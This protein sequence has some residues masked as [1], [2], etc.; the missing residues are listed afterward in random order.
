MSSMPPLSSSNCF[1][2]LSVEEVYES[3]SISSTD[4]IVNNPKAVLNTSP[5]QS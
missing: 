5:L 3:N 2:V 1:T 4:D